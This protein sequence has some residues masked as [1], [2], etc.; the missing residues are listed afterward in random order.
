MKDL[1][2]TVCHHST[3]VPRPWQA[4]LLARKERLKHIDIATDQ[5]FR[6]PGV[7][8]VK[9]EVSRFVV[10]VNRRRNDAGE[11]G[12]FITRSW[13]HEEVW[14]TPLTPEEKA[15]LLKLYYDPFFKRLEKLMENKENVLL[16]DGHSMNPLGGK[17]SVD[18]EKVRPEIDLACNHFTA[19]HEEIVLEA[20]R[21][22]EEKGYETEIDKPYS[23]RK[24]GPINLFSVPGK[25][26]A[27]I[28]EVNKKLY[29]KD[30]TN[31]ASVSQESV[32]KLNTEIGEIL[33]KL[34][35]VEVTQQKLK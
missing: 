2:V 31:P 20:K 16:I 22:F 24:V 18:P 32:K 21:L 15:I 13:D 34:R 11:K 27:M 4:R 9:A 7:P 28:L 26:D 5:I 30:I 12:V 17:N 35:K 23:G 33:N 10:D 3:R 29:M 14:K 19:C 8:T 1:V 25:I 6:F